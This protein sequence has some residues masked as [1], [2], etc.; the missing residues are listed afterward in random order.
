MATKKIPNEKPVAK[1][2]LLDTLTRRKKSVKDFLEN[3][4]IQDLNTLK[5]ILTTLSQEYSISNDLVTQAEEIIR[6]IPTVPVLNV[7]PEIL[8]PVVQEDSV[9][10]ESVVPEEPQVKKRGRKAK[11]PEPSE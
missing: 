5:S 6:L 7:K 8:I 1:P 3:I 2:D 9:P 4:G 10:V 11:D